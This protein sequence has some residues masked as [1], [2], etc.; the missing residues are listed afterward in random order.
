MA[1]A[2]R[3]PAIGTRRGAVAIAAAATPV[4][5]AAAGRSLIGH[6]D[7]NST[8]GLH[9]ASDAA[10]TPATDPAARRASTNV[11]HTNSAADSGVTTYGP[12]GA[13]IRIAAAISS[14][15]PGA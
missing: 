11:V 3:H 5:I 1:S 9:A 4:Q 14:G 12:S 7:M 6:T 13:C 10:M 2:A 15:M 8:I